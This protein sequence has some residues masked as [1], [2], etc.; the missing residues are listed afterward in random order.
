MAIDEFNVDIN[1]INDVGKSLSSAISEN[2]KIKASA[3]KIDAGLVSSFSPSA[4][5]NVDAILGAVDNLVSSLTD[6]ETSYGLA[7]TELIAAYEEAQRKVEEDLKSGANG[8]QND[9]NP[10]TENSYLSGLNEK[11]AFY[12]NYPQAA[13][14]AKQVSSDRVRNLLE[15]N[16]AKKID[17]NVYLIKVGK[18]EYRYNVNTSLLSEEGVRGT[19]YAKFFATEDANFSNITNTI[20]IMGG[21]GTVNTNHVDANLN[22]GVKI[23]KNSLVILPYGK[24]IWQTPHLVA[25]ST[26]IG[27]FLV[28]GNNKIVKNSIVGYSLGGQIAAK[29]VANNKGLYRNI[30][31]V[32]SAA[33]TSDN[34][35]GVVPNN[36]ATYDAFKDV[37]VIFFEGAGDKFN[38]AAGKT[39]DVFTA[40]G[41]PRNNFYVYTTDD[42]LIKNYKDKLGTKHLITPPSSYPVGGKRGWKGHSYGFNM[43]KESGIINY[44]GR[45]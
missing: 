13:L 4:N 40:N 8:G 33:Y 32:N 45:I 25:G 17:N 42:Y 43:I 38:R 1:A 5:G 44:L 10:D 9:L 6:L 41:V 26:R 29:A 11:L 27:D 36:Q 37:N 19:M 24:G 31:F 3:N 7:K 12:F 39:I 22:T 15:K 21:S 30:V 18:K 23:D 14:E 20:T 34:G 28:G 35:S 2:Q 16:G